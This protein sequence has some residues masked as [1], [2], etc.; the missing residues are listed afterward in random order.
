MD[1]QYLENYLAKE[2]EEYNRFVIKKVE[3]G[4]FDFDNDRYPLDNR[5]VKLK[6]PVTDITLI[7]CFAE[8]RWNQVPF[9]GST[10][11]TIDA[12]SPEIFEKYYFKISEIPRIIDFIK[13]TG[14]VQI[15]LRQSPILYEGLDYLD[16]IFKELEPPYLRGLN[17]TS[18]GTEKELSSVIDAFFMLS[19]I[20]FEDN[21]CGNTAHF[22]RE[23]LLCRYRDYAYEYAVLKLRYPN[24]AEEIENA[25]IDE[26]EKVLPML[27]ASSNF[28]LDPIK[29]IRYD[30]L[31][32][33]FEEI[34][35]GK[36]ALGKAMEPKDLR[37]PCEIGKFLLTKLTYSPKGLRACN[38]LIDHYYSYDLQKVLAS[39]NEA[40][41]NNKPQIME[42]SVTSVSEI[43]DNV[44]KDKT[45]MSNIKGLKVGIPLSIA[46][47]GEIVSGPIGGLTGLLSG[48]G[49]TV[50]SGI[51]TANIDGLT[52]KLVKKFSKSYQA[53]IYDFKNTYKYYLTK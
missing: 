4:T 2:D 38:E 23:A 28:L 5:F 14:K 44:W 31:T 8:D 49:F 53:N 34:K 21:L 25:L 12:C 19:K 24:I 7:D 43:L 52:E 30:S 37:F 39:L 42:E 15:V 45:I 41:V 16:P 33:S 11:F 46:V 50:G 51:L 40:I 20:K 26:P 1:K 36:G 3:A 32:H 48:L 17:F 9:N 47:I 29:N 27:N 22:S 6:K 10:I 18:F 35:L 13:D